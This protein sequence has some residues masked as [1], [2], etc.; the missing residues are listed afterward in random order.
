MQVQYGEDQAEKT[1]Q[2]HREKIQSMEAAAKESERKIE[3][4][5]HTVETLRSTQKENQG[6]IQGMEI[7]T[8]KTN[9]KIEK[10]TKENRNLEEKIQHLENV[11][12]NKQQ[13]ISQLQA[14]KEGV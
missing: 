7:D 10:L 2:I 5:A 11:I 3:D 4:L 8:L 6:K 14:A 13:E 9:D 12:K 1:A